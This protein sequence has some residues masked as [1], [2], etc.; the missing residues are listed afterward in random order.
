MD[1]GVLD[2]VLDDL[3]NETK[4]HGCIM[5]VSGFCDLYACGHVFYFMS[6]I[7]LHFGVVIAT[8][9]RLTCGK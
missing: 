1:F 7:V 9:V 4:T 8:N 6:C 3:Q 5:Y 2:G